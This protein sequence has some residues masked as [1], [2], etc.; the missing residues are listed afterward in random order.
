MPLNGP[1]VLDTLKYR[2]EVYLY[3]GLKKRKVFM[4]K[5]FVGAML[6]ASIFI[7]ACGSSSTSEAKDNC[8]D[9]PNLPECQQNEEEQQN[10]EPEE[11]EPSVLE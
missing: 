3:Y 11:Q 4:N 5:I 9:D 2:G 8:T 10:T 6:I 7:G 1:V